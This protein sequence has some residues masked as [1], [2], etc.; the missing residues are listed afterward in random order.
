MHMPQAR[1]VVVVSLLAA[2][3]ACSTA[4]V[5]A[6][7]ETTTPPASPAARAPFSLRVL[8]TSDEHGWLL[9]HTDKK[10]GIQR[11]GIHAIAGAFR[12]EG[13]SADA[14]SWLLLSSGDMWTGPYETTVL[15]GAPMTASMSH[16]GYNGAAVGNHEFDFGQRVV[17]ERARAATFP[18]LAAN[19]TETATG[20]V[21]AWA[22]PYVMVEQ[23]VD[24]GGTAR[25]A[26]IGLACVES[27]VTAD[28]RNMVG[29][30]FGDYQPALERVLP[31]VEAEHPDAIVVVAHDSITKIRPVLPLLRAHK[32]AV[33]AAGHE[34]K[35]NIFVDDNGTATASDDIVVCNPGPYLRSFCRVD[36]D[37]ENGQATA[38]REKLMLVEHAVDAPAPP[39]D[40]ALTKIVSDAEASA[41]RIGGEVLIDNEQKLTRGKDGSLGQ[42]VVD[43]WLDALPYAQVALTN[44]GGIRQDIDA[45]PLRIRDIVS[46]LPFNNYLLVVDMTGKELR[47]VLANPES[48][49]AGVTWHYTTAA[50]GTRVVGAVTTTAGKVIN[51]DDSFKVIINDFMFRGGDR[52]HF[53]DVEPEETAVDWREPVF[54]YL[55]NEHAHGR[56]LSRA[57]AARSTEDR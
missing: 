26:I 8:L 41:S 3:L 25:V 38:H 30:D 29:L 42:V 31:Q 27:P 20:A 15:E 51:D 14:P 10:A 32:V 21:P 52:Y 34:H 22:R 40:E 55:R 28:V 56:A 1:V 16:L 50:D 5:S 48:I 57:P 37:Y 53:V 47:S 19:L 44:A 33:V 17:I 7:A 12:S 18:F 54:R 36:V 24:D 49:A 46:A 39:F 9:P 35:S 45:G 6:P 11:G 4:P 23:P 43:A 2:A 13:Y